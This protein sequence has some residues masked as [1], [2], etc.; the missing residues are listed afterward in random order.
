MR[1]DAQCHAVGAEDVDGLV[2]L[3]RDESIDLVVVG[4]EVPLVLGLADTIREA[5]IAC[6]GPGSD[7]ARLEGSKEWAK[8]LMHAADI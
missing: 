3:A 8:D 1:S 4:P 2:S 6:F 7:G 5:G